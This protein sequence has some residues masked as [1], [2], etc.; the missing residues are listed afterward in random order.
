M[1]S[2]N[3]FN[4]WWKICDV[5]IS[6]DSDGF[7]W[8]V[9][10]IFDDTGKIAS[11]GSPSTPVQ[12]LGWRSLPVLGDRFI[13][14]ESEVTVLSINELILCK[15]FLNM[16]EISSCLNSLLIENGSSTSSTFTLLNQLNR[17]FLSTVQPRGKNAATQG[18]YAISDIYLKH[19]Q[20]LLKRRY[21]H[22]EN[23][24][25]VNL[26]FMCNFCSQEIAKKI[27]RMKEVKE[28]RERD[29]LSKLYENNDDSRSSS[30]HE[31][32]GS[33][34]KRKKLP[35]RVKLRQEAAT[36]QKEEANDYKLSLIIKGMLILVSLWCPKIYFAWKVDLHNFE[37][38]GC[39]TMAQSN[40]KWMAS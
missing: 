19:W 14:V 12:I 26:A 17:R 40:L 38:L 39:C 33:N 32:A 35:M 18:R 29:G 1:K 20:E 16:C 7:L 3:S 24:H 27:I 22:D 21:I 10:Q 5:L 6:K 4:W 28:K 37:M 31:K 8:Q 23:R 11:Y 30:S 25:I 36:Q 34:L 13:A 2:E 15:M 9:R